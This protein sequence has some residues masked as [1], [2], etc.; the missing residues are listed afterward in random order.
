MLLK[1]V[2]FLEAALDTN[3]QYLSG[4]GPKR[5]ALYHKLDIHTIRDLLYYFPRAY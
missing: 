2:D 3:I 5:A 1:G 4:V